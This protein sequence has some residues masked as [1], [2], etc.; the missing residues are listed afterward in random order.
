MKKYKVANELLVKIFNDILEIEESA[1]RNGEFSNLSVREIHIIDAI[2]IKEQ[3]MM[4]EVAKDLNIT[5]G[6]LTTAVDRLIKKGYVERN[7][8]EEDRR[9]VM[10]K[11]TE[12][13]IKAKDIH[14]EFHKEMVNSMMVDQSEEEIEILLISLG[15]LNKYFKNKYEKMKL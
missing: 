13:G 5:V 7:R 11:I 1:L 12:K 2:G 10:V 6:T 15:K 14:E 8:I 9:V 4:T 3:R